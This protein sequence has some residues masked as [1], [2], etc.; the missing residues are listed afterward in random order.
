MLRP[1][2]V[3]LRLN[4]ELKMNKLQTTYL[5]STAVLTADRVEVELGP[6]GLQLLVQF[7]T[8]HVAIPPT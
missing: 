7:T 4:G 8:S 6:H 1:V 3:A 5:M 2:A